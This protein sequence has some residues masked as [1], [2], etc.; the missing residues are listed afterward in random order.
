MKE[1]KVM[2]SGWDGWD[3]DD[4]PYFIGTEDECEAWIEART[5]AENLGPDEWYEVIHG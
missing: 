5:E 1:C 4:E 3:Y 2:F